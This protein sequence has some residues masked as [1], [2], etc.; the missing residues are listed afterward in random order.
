MNETTTDAIWTET[1]HALI[2]CD[3]ATARA[4]LDS[5]ARRDDNRDG[6]CDPAAYGAPQHVADR[7]HAVNARL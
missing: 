2:A 7:I 1:H 6:F 4:G 3:W 5:L